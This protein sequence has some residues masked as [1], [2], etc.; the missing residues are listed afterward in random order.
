M[1]YVF[2]NTIDL[3]GH[4][5]VHEIANSLAHHYAYDGDWCSSQ[6]RQLFDEKNTNIL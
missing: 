4:F 3:L 5:R 2:G 1:C 6:V